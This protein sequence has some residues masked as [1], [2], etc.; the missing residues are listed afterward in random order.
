MNVNV[1]LRRLED[2]GATAENAASRV[3]AMS[4]P[5]FDVPCV[6]EARE[7]LRKKVLGREVN[8]SIDYVLPKSEQSN[9][10]ERLCCTVLFGNTCVVI[11]IRVYTRAACSYLLREP[12]HTFKAYF[13]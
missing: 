12:K 3:R 7:M 11:T 2:T 8:V 4:R 5:L 6:F 10:P 9:M 13:H 1:C